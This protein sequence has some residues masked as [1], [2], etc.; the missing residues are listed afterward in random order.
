[1]KVE[2]VLVCGPRRALN[3][4][5]IKNG[6]DYEHVECSDCGAPLMRRPDPDLPAHA[7]IMCGECAANLQ[8]GKAEFRMTPQTREAIRQ[9]GMDP[10]AALDKI[11]RGMQPSLLER[12]VIFC[13]HRWYDL[14]ILWAKFRWQSDILRMAA[15]NDG[16][17]SESL[18]YFRG[19]ANSYIRTVAAMR[20]CRVTW[21]KDHPEEHQEDARLVFEN[22]KTK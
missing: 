16:D 4:I 17:F 10:N 3:P 22:R 5:E 18:D 12:M 20:W 15:L 1:M 19:H 2:T 7:K 11:R 21:P 6:W 13:I 8:G 9:A 14:E